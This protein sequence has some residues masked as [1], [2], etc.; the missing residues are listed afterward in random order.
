MSAT[1][2]AFH[3]SGRRCAGDGCTADHWQPAHYWWRNF[4][5]CR[6]WGR[7]RRLARQCPWK[8]PERLP[9]PLGG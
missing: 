3:Q 5:K 8:A 4:I 1:R 6:R 9:G 7:R 2:A